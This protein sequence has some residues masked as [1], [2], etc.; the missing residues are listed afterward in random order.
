[1]RTRVLPSCN[2]LDHLP[3]DEVEAKRR[4][5]TAV[6]PAFVLGRNASVERP[7]AAEFVLS[8]TCHK[9]HLLSEQR[10]GAALP[11]KEPL[12]AGGGAP[13]LHAVEN[14]LHERGRSIQADTQSRDLDARPGKRWGCLEFRRC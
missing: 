6:R 12:I 4:A 1:M 3:P 5:L 13:P 2:R 8:E 7:F 9:A 14:G 11:P 10:R